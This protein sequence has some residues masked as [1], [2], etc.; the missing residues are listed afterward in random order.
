MSLE[1]THHPAAAT[2]PTSS[3]S[4]SRPETPRCNE[5][6]DWDKVFKDM[7]N[8]KPLN[9]YELKTEDVIV[10]APLEENDNSVICK[11]DDPCPNF[12]DV[13]QQYGLWYSSYHKYLG[14][15]YPILKKA[16]DAISSY[17][18][19]S[20][21]ERVRA[22]LD[23]L[24]LNQQDDLNQYVPL[25]Y[26]AEFTDRQG[27]T[28]PISHMIIVPVFDVPRLILTTEKEHRHFYEYIRVDQPVREY[29]DLELSDWRRVNEL[30]EE[31]VDESNGYS[32]LV[33]RFI[34]RRIEFGDKIGITVEHNQFRITSATNNQ[35]ISYHIVIAGYYWNRVGELGAFVQAF[36]EYL[37][38][39]EPLLSR[40]LDD[41]VYNDRL[42]RT[43]GSVKYG[44]ERWLHLRNYP[45]VGPSG[46]DGC[47]PGFPPMP[48]KYTHKK[49][50]QRVHCYLNDWLEYFITLTPT[51]NARQRQL[52][53]NVLE[54][55]TYTAALGYEPKE[56]IGISGDPGDVY[57]NGIKI[58]LA[59]LVSSNKRVRDC[60]S[61]FEVRSYNEERRFWIL[62]RQQPSMCPIH[63]RVHE[64]ENATVRAGIR[65]DGVSLLFRCFNAVQGEQS[66][67]MTV[68][69]NCTKLLDDDAQLATPPP[70]TADTEPVQQPVD[71][72]V[73]EVL[74]RYNIKLDFRPLDEFIPYDA[75]VIHLREK[76]RDTYNERIK[77]DGHS[78]LSEEEIYIGY[79]KAYEEQLDR[80]MHDVPRELLVNVYTERLFQPDDTVN[81]RPGSNNL[82]LI[83]RLLEFLYAEEKAAHLG[84]WEDTPDKFDAVRKLITR[85][86]E[87]M[88]NYRNLTSIC[89]APYVNAITRLLVEKYGV[90][91]KGHVII[92]A[93]AVNKYFGMLYINTYHAL[94]RH[95]SS[96]YIVYRTLDE[97]GQQRYSRM[98]VSAFEKSATDIEVIKNWSKYSR[99]HISYTDIRFRPQTDQLDVAVLNTWQGIP[100][101]KIGANQRMSPDPQPFFDHIR[102]IICNGN[103]QAT[104]YFINLLALKVQRPW[105]R[106]HIAPV[107]IGDQGTGKTSFVKKFGE[108]LG[109]YFKCSSFSKVATG[110][111]YSIHD[112]LL[113]LCDEETSQDAKVK[114][115]EVIKDRI[116]NDEWD[117][118][119]K[120]LPTVSKR[121]YMD[122]IIASNNRNPVKVEPND[123]R[124]FVLEVSDRYKGVASKE[125]RDYFSRLCNVDP[126]AIYTALMEHTIP[127]D[128][129]SLDIP[130]TAVRRRL[131]NLNLPSPID[132]L[133]SEFA[134]E[135]DSGEIQQHYIDS[136]LTPTPRMT[137]REGNWYWPKQKQCVIISKASLY[138]QYKEWCSR[139][140]IENKYKEKDFISILNEFGF[141]TDYRNPKIHDNARCVILPDPF[142]LSEYFTEKQL[143]VE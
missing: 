75:Y 18:R 91:S 80:L 30:T 108:V 122:F 56:T 119:E 86:I 50:W 141:F 58:N 97:N 22:L 24:S 36:K 76:A 85:P 45:A 25:A 55:F 15:R 52:P 8:G 126:Y 48:L 109:T 70:E 51:R 110:F 127:N 114:L 113:I 47:P 139:V 27:Q 99:F 71:P 120:Y 31:V 11:I 54:R 138:F 65:G 33:K 83:I 81:T 143:T 19:K 21:R 7:L 66:Y 87:R 60:L 10:E 130:D 79:L 121:V 96:P 42:M 20:I 53:D 59:E 131:K 89:K 14:L 142:E 137:K 103:Q 104:D 112:K 94:I 34:N 72:Y 129:S 88:F 74:S 132:F 69:N 92:L 68:I 116:T 134:W 90:K 93:A 100:I 105:Q 107:L 26:Q 32:V 9:L 102:N 133:K 29:Y 98:T 82:S 2:E 77:R 12:I 38:A 6:I 16:T 123:R 63:H 95:D 49:E 44:S 3:A 43:I 17:S 118:E 37:A 67:L 23:H 4:E 128:F 125:T 41:K 101:A 13:I 1:C 5:R 111:N 84:A 117:F 115:T 35:K 28:H 61:G 64:H 106:W 78:K 39:T 73:I 46:R 135:P 124:F 62:D 140:G 57:I 136:L 40:M